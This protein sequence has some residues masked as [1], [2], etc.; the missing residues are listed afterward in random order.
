MRAELERRSEL[1]TLIFI[2]IC[3]LILCIICTIFV[4]NLFLSPSFADQFKYDNYGSMGEYIFYIII[5]LILIIVGFIVFVMF[6]Y[7]SINQIKYLLEEYNKV[8]LEI[9][10]RIAESNAV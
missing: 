9:E 5:W 1:K 2:Y 3:E 8:N 4:L 10:Q 6:Y 7:L